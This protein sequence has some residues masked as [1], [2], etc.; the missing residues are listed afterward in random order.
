[1]DSCQS[2]D[3]HDALGYAA[4]VLVMATFGM[5][6]MVAL[7][8]VAMASN[9]A[10]IG[11]GALA[12]IWPVLGLHLLLLPLNGIRLLE[13]VRQRRFEGLRRRLC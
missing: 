12:G 13:A 2:A 8:V 1:M 10:F 7:R 11:Y 4:S 3:A 9:V 6:G 5:R